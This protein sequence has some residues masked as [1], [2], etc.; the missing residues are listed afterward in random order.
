MSAERLID[1]ID[2]RQLLNAR[3]VEKLREKVAQSNETMSA[4][5][6]AKFLVVK[7]HLASS[8]AAELVN[9]AVSFK[10][11]PQPPAAEDS[12]SHRPGDSSIFGNEFAEF[13]P[14]SKEEEVFTLTP[15]DSGLD[16]ED[17]IPQLDSSILSAPPIGGIEQMTP[18]ESFSQPASLLTE[19]EQRVAA[20]ASPMR[21]SRDRA[22]VSAIGTP[23][24]TSP[25]LRKKSKKKN[26]W[27]SPM[28]LIGGGVLVLLLICGATVAL[29]LNRRGGDEKLAEARQYRDA[30]AFPAAI[31]SYK[32][33]VDG[34]STDASWNDARMELLLVKLRQAVESGGD[35]LP[36][37]KIAQTELPALES[38]KSFDQQKLAEARPELADILP[39]IATGLAAQ[40][41]AATDP[42]VAQSI[43]QSA[44]DALVLCR[45]AKYVSKELRNDAALGEVEA[46]L[47]RVSRRQET[48]GDLAKGLDEIKAAITAGDPRAA[49]AAHRKLLEQHPELAAD[50]SLQAIIIE[51]SAAELAGIKLVADEHAAETTE[52]KTPWL[53]MLST[54]NRQVIADAPAT[55]VFPARIDG[56]LD[57]F[58]VA[59]GRLLWRR[60]V[61]FATGLPPV[62]V[63]ESV[64]AFDTKHQELLC[65]A[66][67][68]GKLLWR[69]EI[70][71][72]VSAPLVV[73]EQVFVAAESGRLYVIELATGVRKGYLQF[74]Q[75]LHTPPTVDRTGKR[76]YLTGDHSSIYSISLADLKCQGV[77]HLGH[78]SGSIR[79]PP[80]QILGRLAVLENDGVATSRL[81]I[82]S[83]NEDG[84]V[85]KVETER[86]LQGLAAS[87]PLVTGRRLIVVTDRGELDAYDLATT[88]GENALTQVATREATS[89]EPLVRHVLLTQG[90][91]WVG[92]NQ[93]TKF[94]VL[95]TG[96]RLPVVT[97]DDSFVRSTFDHPMALFGSVLVHVRRVDG[98]AGVV[99]TAI[100]AESGRTLWKN[101]LAV[102]PASTPIVD[103]ANRTLALA[104]VNGLVY[105]FDD[106]ALR[107]RV[108][109]EPLSPATG[110]SRGAKLTSGVDLGAGR[111][112]FAAPGDGEQLVLYDPAAPRSPVRRSTMPSK[113]AC[114]LTAFG[115]GVLVP[116]E[117]GQVFY[118]NPADGQPLAAPFQPRLTPGAKV[119]FQPAGQVGSNGRQ[120]VISDGHEKIFLVELATDPQP[121]LQPIAEKSVGAFPIVSAV[122]VVGDTAF[123]A[124]DGGQLTRFALPSLENLGQTA[125]PGD[126][127]WGPYPIGELLLVAT[128]KGE[129]VAVNGDGAIAWSDAMQEGELA[130]PPLAV[131]GGFLL[132]YR[133]G[134]V[135]RRGTADGAV[136]ARLD[137]EH[138][139]AAG[140]VRLSDRVVLTSHDG[141]LLVVDMP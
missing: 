5:A 19:P 76:L 108:Q 16:Q 127:V 47:A 48:R 101:E 2:E 135:E 115:G 117:V 74:A 82:L 129:L 90:A 118:L 11:L 92:D 34:Y 84:A 45:N 65:L 85:D 141:T 140:P 93:L 26:Q 104:D 136:A 17:S 56:A 83:L 54:G 72:P 61:G 114:S 20:P 133:K 58:D 57:A 103:A 40:A 81:R 102:P 7:K 119:L 68:S 79:V 123:A 60:Y 66:A 33:F 111:A 10:P 67:Q 78:S 86:R 134:I 87:P 96:N 77:F 14:A 29:I 28:F 39:R 94:A 124:S 69:Q 18:E 53:A 137:V 55:G 105:R 49:Y 21:A 100:D 52:R 32:E 95:P 75:P 22:K 64:L 120:F 80:V 107:A 132:A 3:L 121:H 51:A 13:A 41:D 116:L 35:L 98:Q 139:L 59:T 37:L 128:A 42:Q 125:L 131:D 24:A 50:E 15:I 38:D 73:G 70:G 97:I 62:S 122:V 31:T 43:A 6:L 110:A 27:D 91:V 30:G 130:G 23:Q 9:E 4:A 44:A 112:A 109:D 106:A 46:K 1:L 8:Q 113:V 25:G 88:E 36:A 138:P 89:R 12:D 99:V 63:Q 126:V 71:E